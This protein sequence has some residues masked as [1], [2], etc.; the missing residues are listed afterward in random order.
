MIDHTS[1]T[2]RAKKSMMGRH[3]DA[4]AKH[5]RKDTFSSAL[6]IHHSIIY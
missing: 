4:G 2:E 3:F 6:S 5:L 1:S